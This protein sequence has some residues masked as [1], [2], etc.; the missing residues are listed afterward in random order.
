MEPGIVEKKYDFIIVGGGIAGLDL[1]YR[2]V[3]SPLANRSILIIDK[4]I[5]D[6]DDRTL[7]FWTDKETIYDSIVYHTWK[8]IR[9]VTDDFE[10]NLGL[11]KFQ[12]KTIRSIDFYNFVWDT[13]SK[14]PNVEFVQG[15]VDEVFDLPEISYVAMEQKR[16]YGKWIFDSRLRPFAVE[17]VLDHQLLRQYFKGWI[18]ETKEEVFDPDKATMF[19]FRI[20]QENDMRFF[21]L[22]PFSKTRALVE[23]VGLERVN[24]DKIGKD[25]IENKLGLKDYSLEDYENG[26]IL[27]TDHRFERQD[28][29]GIMKIGSAGGM[30]KPSSGY[31]FTRIMEDSAAIVESLLENNHPFEVPDVK[32]FYLFLDSQMLKMM[33]LQPGQLKKVFCGMFKYNPAKNIFRFLDE[34]ASVMSIA[35]LVLTMPRKFDFMKN[36]FQYPL[37]P[38]TRQAFKTQLV[39]AEMQSI[40]AAQP[41]CG[42]PRWI[43]GK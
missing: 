27:L 3:N 28:G 24:F 1:A 17:E 34:R 26:V 11:G 38:L 4:E 31:A 14:M 32:D 21:Y 15:Q 40:P 16:Y 20:E 30:V 43:S 10:K 23:Y 7:S 36:I 12:Y 22:L 37:M 33:Y 35:R 9:F 42:I 39:L 13:L 25:Y 8:T 29:Q 18:V 6:H 41:K 19:D 2:L 5:K